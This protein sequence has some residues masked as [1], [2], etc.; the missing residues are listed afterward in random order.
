M[1]LRV[2]YTTDGYICEIL[3]VH[4]KVD[5]KCALPRY[6]AASSSNLLPIGP[7][8]KGLEFLTP[9]HVSDGLSRNVGKKLPLLAA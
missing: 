5:E 6:H 7:I 3:D 2:Q 9:E 4:H 1:I 8:F